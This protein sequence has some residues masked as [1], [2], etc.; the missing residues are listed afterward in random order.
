M[1]IGDNNIPKQK[2]P[3]SK[4]TAKWREGCV[5]AFI[6]LS[7]QGN[8]DRRDRLR[9]LYDYYN[10][11][12]DSTDY[13]YV[14]QPYGKERKNFPS[15]MRNYPIIKPIVD[16]LLGEKAKR[17]LNFSVTV[18]NSDTISEKENAKSQAVMQN[19]EQHFINS[20]Q[21]AGQGPEQGQGAPQEELQLPAYIAEQFEDSY[22]DNRA[23][24]GQYSLNYIMQ[25]QEVHDKF[26][27]AWFHFLVS[28]EAYSHRG[29]R[30][31]E[32]FYDIVN[33]MDVDYD[34]DPDLEFVEDG[35]WA[36]VRRF[37]H[38]STIID[39][40]H[41][42][43]T[44]E[45]VDSLESPSHSETGSFL[46]RPSIGQNPNN[47]RLIE[48]ITVYWKSRKRLGILTY[49][50]PNTGEPEEVEVPEGF[51]V[52][53]EIKEMGASVKYLWI[54]EVWGGTRIDGK[55]FLDIHPL[56]NQRDSLDNPSSCKLPINGRRYSDVNSSNISLVSLGV[57][58]QLT[59]NVYKYR[60][61][62]SI[63]KSKDIIAQFDINMIPKKW[64]MDK[65]MYYVEGTGIAWVDYNKEGVT[66][67]PQHQ[68]V[69]DMSI[70]TI[71]QYIVLLNSIMGE[72]EKL[73]GVN[74]QRQ[75]QVGEYEGKAASQQAIVQSSH[76]T[77]DMFRK[78]ERMEQRDLQALLDYSKEAWL[79]GKKGMFVM[80]DGTTEYLDIDSMSH[81]ESNYGIFVS[82]AGKDLDKLEGIKALTQAMV[83]NGLP[84]S[85][86]AELIDSDNFVKIKANIKKAE[87]SQQQLAA[88]QAEAEQQSQAALAQQAQAAEQARNERE[89]IDK[90]KD[91]QLQRELA[92][93]NNSD[94]EKAAH[95]N[96]QK[97]M[98][99][100]DL[101]EKELDLKEKELAEKSTTSRNAESLQK[102]EQA[103]KKEDLKGKRAQSNKP[104]N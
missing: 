24:K 104:T 1:D 45:Q 36:L 87:K 95:F 60:L 47:N 34:K 29:V 11:I 27:K 92:M 21:A 73:A 32:P 35:D 33:P 80:P 85:A 79:K 101:R 22:V 58:Y 8:N 96:L 46:M 84:M 93:I 50:D 31:N 40:H 100:F 76:I 72:W 12:I 77:E 38:A 6:N 59:Y 5:D 55:H 20:I 17:P 41:D 81:L 30:S 75:G 88:Q 97:A 39:H 102:S 83:Q 28:G 15:K 94:N 66:L 16:L 65:F 26:Q 67:S 86:V 91:R 42:D 9:S 37:V 44:P 2:L 19:M 14:L 10:G 69:L 53:E 90:E 70:K 103:I 48:A 13:K 52:P 64:D 23:I 74:S 62:L 43:L 98:K 63:A 82:N 78:F 7:T 54:N 61:E 25:Q 51:K 68:S 18:Q 99:E 89:D 71:E 4:K 56:A 57:A 3:F 49:V